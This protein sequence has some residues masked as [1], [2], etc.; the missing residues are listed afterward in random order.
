MDCGNGIDLICTLRISSIIKSTETVRLVLC[1]SM[2]SHFHLASRLSAMNV[3][4]AVDSVSSFVDSSGIYVVDSGYLLMISSIAAFC[5]L[6]PYLCCHGDGRF[7]VAIAACLSAVVCLQIVTSVFAAGGYPMENDWYLAIIY[8]ASLTA[9]TFL[10]NLV[11]QQ[12]PS[13]IA[14]LLLSSILCTGLVSGTAILNDAIG[15]NFSGLV[16]LVFV[17]LLML[18]C[19]AIGFRMHDSRFVQNTK[20]Q[21]VASFVTL[22]FVD[23]ILLYAA[24]AELT[25]TQPFIGFNFKETTIFA[26]I[27][28]FYH[29]IYSQIDMRHEAKKSR[30]AAGKML[31]DGLEAQRQSLTEKMALLPDD[32]V[33]YP[34]LAQD[35]TT[36]NAD[37]GRPVQFA[38]LE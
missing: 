36:S 38:P 1:F 26:M 34:P 29:C 20:H 27:L 37:E 24:H 18:V 22:I 16:W 11:T 3:I 10:F 28:L 6:M 25:A 4:G 35:N 23:V 2:L 9:C 32:L 7:L 12:L 31:V 13:M 30:K 15:T 14:T 21:L 5:L 19:M 33:A 17:G 8:C